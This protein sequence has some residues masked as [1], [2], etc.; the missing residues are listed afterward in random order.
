MKSKSGHIF[1]IIILIT[2]SF[3]PKSKPR[4]QNF[5][6]AAGKVVDANT[7]KPLPY[8]GLRIS[9]SRLINI[10]QANGS[11]KLKIPAKYQKHALIISYLG[12][13]SKTI[14]LSEFEKQMLTIK[15]QPTDKSI[16]EVIVKPGLAESLIEKALKKIPDNYPDSAKNHMAY[17]RE[18]V[19]DNGEY[20]DYIELIL[21]V[22][23]TPYTSKF[24]ND[25]IQVLKGRQAKDLKISKFY[26]YVYFVDGP[27]EALRCDIAKYPKDFISI[28]R[29]YLSFLYPRHFKFYYYSLRYQPEL[30][31]DILIIDFKPKSK[32]AFYKGSLALHR[33]TLS[34]LA[35]YYTIDK[36]KIGE[37]RLMSEDV[38]D[39]LN[40]QDIYN[41]NLNYECFAEY[42]YKAGQAQFKY[43]SLSYSYLWK[44]RNLN[45]S[46]TIE[47]H[48]ELFIR[49]TLN[50]PAEP[51]SI[52]KRFMYAADIRNQIPR[53]DIAFDNENDIPKPYRSIMREYLKSSTPF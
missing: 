43:A 23:K 35:L 51:I 40:S 27:Y 29:H 18:T 2:L 21:N 12:Y 38:S 25:Q 4:A 9:E 39:Y 46:D 20:C 34:F 14:G 32:R 6:T 47:Y 26:D 37:S 36:N 31:E 33:K 8:S 48:S 13:E 52:W 41:Q 16:A 15:L 10:S 49:R 53:N 1:V 30:G 22:Y 17:Y 44:D 5:I 50:K 28:P 3:A 45:T 7:N 11:F 42:E 19:K 24:K